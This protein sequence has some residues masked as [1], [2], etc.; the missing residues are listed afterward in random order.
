MNGL[1]GK[2]AIVTGS[3]DGIGYAIARRLGKEGAKVVVSSRK[4]KNVL[5]AVDS[6]RKEGIVVEG[7]VCNVG[8]DA[9]R[10]KLVKMTLE[11]FGKID[12]LIS[13]AGINPHYGS[14]L[15]VSDEIWD[16]LFSV[17]VKA[18]FSLSKLVV[19]HMEKN[20][21]SIVYVSSVAGYNSTAGIAAYGITKTA[22][23]GL[24]KAMAQACAEKNIRVNCIAPGL[25]KTDFSRAAWEVPDSETKNI[26]EKMIPMNRLGTPDECAGTVAF[27]CSNDASYITGESVMI[28]G[29]VAARL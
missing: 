26:I 2:V 11:K 23:L 9:D 15:D 24:T 8:V 28:G 3:T 5:K 1:S 6:L 10:Q 29:G 27:L 21:G 18:G 16:K 14:L 17:N 4:E 13:N 19:P 22:L 20:G 12:M 7:T 25:I